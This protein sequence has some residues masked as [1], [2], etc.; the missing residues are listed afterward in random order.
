MRTH[1]FGIME[2]PRWTIAALALCA[3]SFAVSVPALAE[4]ADEDPTAQGTRVIALDKPA[5]SL[6][7]LAPM[8]QFHVPPGA[9]HGEKLWRRARDRACDAM[10]EQ[11]GGFFSAADLVGEGFRSAKNFQSE[12]YVA[13]GASEAMRYALAA[14]EAEKKGDK[15][16]LTDMYLVYFTGEQAAAA[17]VAGLH[18]APA[19]AAKKPDAKTPV[20]GEKPKNEKNE[21]RKFSIPSGSRV[22]IKAP[23][24]VLNLTTNEGIASGNSKVGVTLEVFERTADGA[25]GPQIAVMTSSQLRW[26]TWSEPAV[27]STELTL[28]ACAEKPGDPDP[29]VT[30]TYFMRDADGSTTTIIV[31][32]C[33]MVY[34]TGTYDRPNE[35]ADEDGRIAGLSNVSRDR[36]VFHSKIKMDTTET[37]MAAVIPF[38]G[39][40]PAKKT[41][42]PPA[43]TIVECD[44]PAEF[45][46]AAVPRKAPAVT[47]VAA[48]DP[49]PILLGRRFDF[50]NHVHMTKVVLPVPGALPA[51]PEPP[52]EM[53]C[54][55]LRTLYPPGAMP[56]A[57]A[58]PEYSEAIGGVNMRGVDAGTPAT[59]DTPAIAPSPFSIKCNR[60]YFDGAAD[61]MFL[62]G[63]LEH[64]AELKHAEKGDASAQ[65]LCFRRQTQ[66]LTMPSKG[67]KTMVI[68][69]PPTPAKPGAGQSISLSASETTLTW[70]GP[71]YR[72]IKHLPVPGGADRLKEVMTLQ[73]D[74]SIAQPSGGLNLRGQKV[75]IM[76]NLDD[77]NVEFIESAGGADA[78]M[79]ELRAKGEYLKVEMAYAADGTY[80]KNVTTVIG[81]RATHTKAMLFME[82]SA[83][84]SDKFIVDRVANTFVSF[85]GA[86][87]VI[88]SPQPEQPVGPKTQAA[89]G[90]KGLIKDI[91]LAPGGRMFIQCD[92]EFSQDGAAHTVTIKKNVLITQPGVR[93]L[94]D[95]VYLT[96]DD[97]PPAPA[98]T[99]ASTTPAL[100][101]NGELKQIDCRGAVE[102]TTDDQLIQC[103]RLLKDVKNDT[104]LLEVSDPDNDVRVYLSQEGGSRVLCVK[105]SLTL[106]GKTGTFKP[107]GMMLMLPFRAN[108]P[109]PRDKASSP[110][111][112]KKK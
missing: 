40:A 15:V 107:S 74:V 19:G 61:H 9:E 95:E 14:K 23:H 111:R 110:A 18:G 28:Y 59:A 99:Q 17:E 45:D 7:A 26:R 109:A 92:G 57:T 71:L 89:E 88:Q 49:K 52:T 79:G 108:A 27:G 105:K 29:L 86:V 46:L 1:R 85:G 68:R 22:V 112:G 42:G 60:V 34:E 75:R 98:G 62:V 55:H 8:Q 97:P 25:V 96:M 69:P 76:R 43:R 84:R 35:V 63:D 4:E 65:Q 33:G 48:S 77:G 37:A 2:F 39:A 83:V 103:E 64:P 5:Q 106:D 12:H 53:T 73:Q 70:S 80:T 24:A 93:L 31:Q 3:F 44:G 78:S 21:G 66:T 100:F 51:P 11:R 32:G 104:S 58:F 6:D 56:S 20:S 54:E 90:A 50:L 13:N 72:E 91:S 10:P 101:N 38:Q 82:G 30:G 102:L 94:A 67:P 36:A 87:A 47:G 41:P 16:Y 81:N